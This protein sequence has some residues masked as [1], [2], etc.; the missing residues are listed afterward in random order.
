M[1]VGC[2]QCGFPVTDPWA[3]DCPRCLM[4]LEAEDVPAVRPGPPR[5]RVGRLIVLIV[6]GVCVLVLGANKA[7]DYVWA[8]RHLGPPGEADSTGRLR[9]GMPMHEVARALDGEP[10]P[11]GLPQVT[12]SFYPGMTGSGQLVWARDGR[13]VRVNFTRGVAESIEEG[14]I[15]PANLQRTEVSI[16]L[17]GW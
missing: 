13:I 5:P 11:Q 8:S 10:Q 3:D 9:A 17:F 15:A 2:R 12:E 6:L 16:S 14:R 1:P 7:S 4:P